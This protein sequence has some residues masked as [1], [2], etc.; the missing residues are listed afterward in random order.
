MG[1]FEKPT[2]S[3]VWWIQYFHQGQ[4]H[5]EKVGSKRLAQAAYEQR[6]TE[7]RQGKFTAEMVQP[8]RAI[9][10]AEMIERYWAYFMSLRSTGSF[11]ACRL[12]WVQAYGTLPADQLTPA[13]IDSF[14]RQLLDHVKPATTNRYFSFL[15]RCYTL[16]VRD[17]LV[18]SNP[19]SRTKRLNEGNGRVRWLTPDEEVLLL[20]QLDQVGRHIVTMA[21]HTGMRQGELFHVRWADIDLTAGWITIPRTKNGDRRLVPIN[22]T[23]RSVLE[24]RSKQGTYVFESRRGTPLDAGN[25]YNRHFKPATK[26]MHNLVFHDLRHT[27]CSRLAMAGVPIAIIKELAG[28]KTIQITMRYAHLSPEAGQSA[29]GLLDKSPQLGPGGSEPPG[30]CRLAAMRPAE[31]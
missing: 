8:K 3:G 15:Q 23:V 11:A 12:R 6:K 21:I 28:H 19:F 9:R 24:A 10:I 26:S 25:W 2:G 1:I 22:S 5:R 31:S 4:R 29:V 14:R 20:T 7:C 27:F 17:E 16:A 13:M 30:P 18:A